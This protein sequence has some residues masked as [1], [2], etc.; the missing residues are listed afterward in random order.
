MVYST[1]ATLGG[2]IASGHRITAY[3]NSCRHSVQLDLEALAAKLGPDH[4][5]LH[6]DLVPRLKCSRCGSRSIGLI[7]HHADAERAK[8]PSRY[9]G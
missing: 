9:T 2:C 8:Y 3:C 1:N 7:V 5:A 4:G 6:N